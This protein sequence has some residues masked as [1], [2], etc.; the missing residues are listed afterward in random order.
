[1][2]AGG[3]SRRT[4]DRVLDIAERLVQT[5]GFNGFSYAD[6]A[7]ELAVTKA[8]LH[9]YFPTKAALGRALI[10]RY[11]QVFTR[12]LGAIDAETLRATAKLARYASL[13]KEVLRND[14]MCLCGMVAAEYTTLPEPMQEEIRRFFTANELWLAAVL[15]EGK[16]SGELHLRGT[17]LDTARLLLS[18]L[19]GAM[20]VA[21][22]YGSVARFEISAKRLIA[23]LTATPELSTRSHPLNGKSM[24]SARSRRVSGTRRT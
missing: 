6:I 14:R 23:D 16:R 17:P 12:L 22:S 19:Q 24:G 20:L 18:A 21:R 5:R 8:T 4:A 13:Y 15:D 7:T 3:S 1:M 2:T 11:H 10:E 9:Y